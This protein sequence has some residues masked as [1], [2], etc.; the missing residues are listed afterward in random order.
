[1]KTKKFITFS[2]GKQQFHWLDK[3]GDFKKIPTRK[4]LKAQAKEYEDRIRNGRRE[5][6]RCVGTETYIRQKVIS[7]FDV[8]GIFERIKP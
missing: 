6:Y 2:I 7:S 8:R 3:R 5:N 4:E 1:M